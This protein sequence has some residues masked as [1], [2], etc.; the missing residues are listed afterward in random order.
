MALNAYQFR[1]W[2]GGYREGIGWY[3][4]G[5]WLVSGRYRAGVGTEVTDEVYIAY[6]PDYMI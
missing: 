3:R 6:W 1:K 2:S 4:K 5:I